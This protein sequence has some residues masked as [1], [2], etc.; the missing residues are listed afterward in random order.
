MPPRLI[1]TGPPKPPFH[2]PGCSDR[3]A[4]RQSAQSTSC[5]NNIYC[6]SDEGVALGGGGVEPENEL[7]YE[8]SASRMVCVC[9]CV[10]GGVGWRTD[11]HRSPRQTQTYSKQAATGV[12]GVSD[13]SSGSLATNPNPVRKSNV[14]K[15][16][17]ATMRWKRPFIRGSRSSA[18]QS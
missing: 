18:L 10:W 4:W 14:S 5:G 12:R 16:W 13:F 7:S 17:K 6:C 2:A 15:P 8:A 1:R 3:V 9:V 11:T